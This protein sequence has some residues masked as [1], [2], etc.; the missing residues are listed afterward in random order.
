MVQCSYRQRQEQTK[1]NPQILPTQKTRDKIDPIRECARCGGL[2]SNDR[3]RL[4][5]LGHEA[6]L[7]LVTLRYPRAFTLAPVKDP[8]NV[9]VSL[10]LPEGTS[11]ACPLSGNS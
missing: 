6:L 1:Q 10:G 11:K 7:T 2:C 3:N 8:H 5:F 9:R 4:W